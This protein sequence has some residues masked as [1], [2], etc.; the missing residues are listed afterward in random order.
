MA[1]EQGSNVICSQARVPWSNCLPHSSVPAVPALTSF[2]QKKRHQRQNRDLETIEQLS[3]T[4]RND[5]AKLLC[6][7]YFCCVAH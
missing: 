4:Y 6:I 1:L 2:S 7:C 3:F 5:L